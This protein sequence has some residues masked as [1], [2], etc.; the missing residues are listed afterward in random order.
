M[1]INNLTLK[2]R[3]II[4]VAI[5]CLA[6]IFVG[7]A[8]LNAMSLMGEKTEQMYIN[9][10]SPMRAMAE[11]VSR[12][13]RMRVGIDM[14]LLQQTALRD[15][16]GILTR[17]QETRNEDIPEMR[18]AIILAV[19]AQVNSDLKLA[20]KKLYETFEQVV[21]N[22]LEPMLNALNRDDMAT[23]QQIYRDKY[24]ASYGVMRKEANQ[25]LDTLLQQA[26]MQNNQSR[27][28]YLSGQQAQL[29]IICTALIIAAFVSFIIVRNLG[30][31][32][33]GLKNTMHDAAREL[34]LITRIKPVGKGEFADIANSFNLFIDKIHDSVR[35]VTQNSRELEL[36]ASSASKRAQST[37]SNS[38]MQRDRTIQVAASITQLGGTVSEVA[39]N[40]V[41]AS[42]AANEAI[43]QS[44]SGKTIVEQARSE[45]GT[46]SNELGDTTMI[47]ASLADQVDNISLTLDTIRNISDQTNLLALNAA[48]E[49]ARAGEQGRGFAVVADEVRTLANRSAS[50]TEEIQTIIDKLQ[51]ESKRAVEAMEKGRQQSSRVVE[52]ADNAANALDLINRH[53]NQISEQ[54]IQVATATEEQSNV[55]NDINHNVEDINQLTAETTTFAQQLNDTSSELQSLSSQLTTLVGH[56]KI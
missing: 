43:G 18:H 31:Q 9:T 3:L 10:A 22:E 48:I 23:A 34:S 32:V 24:A 53:I 55:V 56:F 15:E 2:S 54:I 44:A 47:V 14:M 12:I 21:S 50:S 5:P 26:E 37:Q 28:S 16:K 35:L 38:T 4:T 42:E 8:S 11:V 49:A 7:L 13:P 51:T 19:D 6:L 41:R 27:Q 29:L 30:R 45:I 20:V 25:V 46:L 39:Q 33:T 1:F 40:A 52:Y 17:I 36:M